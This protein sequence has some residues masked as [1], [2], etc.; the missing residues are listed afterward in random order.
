MRGKRGDVGRFVTLRSGRVI[1]I[2]G[3]KRSKW[4][5]VRDKIKVGRGKR[6]VV[7]KGTKI[8]WHANL[9]SEARAEPNNDVLVGPKFWGDHMDDETRGW[10][11][12]HEYG[13]VLEQAVRALS[14]EGFDK[15]LEDLKIPMPEWA[16]K[17]DYLWWGYGGNHKVVEAQAD[18]FADYSVG[19]LGEGPIKRYIKSLVSK[20]PEFGGIDFHAIAKELRKGPEHA[21]MTIFDRTE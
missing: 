9:E 11:L 12:A 4:A 6:A 2:P 3:G 7:P 20:R 16:K 13:H 15:A 19:K 1:F 21:L 14:G 8:R 10:V 5:D 17:A 18:A